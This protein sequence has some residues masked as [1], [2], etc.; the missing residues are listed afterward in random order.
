MLYSVF[1]GEIQAVKSRD[2]GILYILQY[3]TR[4]YYVSL[5]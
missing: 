4:S 3:P 5:Q 1:F 2:C